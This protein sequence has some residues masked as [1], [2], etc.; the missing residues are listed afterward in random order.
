MTINNRE[1]YYLIDTQSFIWYVE[2]DTRLPQAI[3]DK[4]EQPS[5]H[6]LVSIASLWEITIKIGLR[7]LKLA[8]TLKTIFEHIETSGFEVLLIETKHLLALE[9]LAAFHK[10]P[11][12]RLIISQ[13]ISESIPIISSDEMFSKYPLKRIWK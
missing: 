11:F 3:K 8:D 4:M 2:D 10:D 12:D 6:L 9:T 7:K 5:T 1:R 13:A